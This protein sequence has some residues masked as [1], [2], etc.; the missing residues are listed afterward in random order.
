M[1]LEMLFNNLQAHPGGGQG[2]LLAGQPVINGSEMAGRL[3]VVGAQATGLL[4]EHG[5]LFQPALRQAA[6]PIE[7]MR[8]EQAGIEPDG[9]LKFF[10]GLVVLFLE[11]D[12]Q[13]ARHVGLGK[14]WVELQRFPA[15]RIR[16]R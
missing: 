13:A 14:I 2:L 1:E 8:F 6:P 16:R 11:R 7:V 15:G 12:G 3:V 5:R 10:A 4:E 9:R